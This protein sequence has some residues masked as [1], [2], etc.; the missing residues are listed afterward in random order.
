MRSR[1]RLPFRAGP[2]KGAGRTRSVT[3]RIRHSEGRPRV[4]WADEL[5]LRN[6]AGRWRVDD[7]AY[8]ATFAFKS[9]SAPSLRESLKGIPAC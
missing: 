6:E 9:G 1:R 8:R 2:G 7:I 4:E 3:V 5:V